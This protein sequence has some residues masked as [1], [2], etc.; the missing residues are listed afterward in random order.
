VNVFILNSGRCGSTTFIRACAHIKNFSAGHETRV[1]RIGPARLAYP[2]NHIEADNRLSWRLGSLDAVYGDRAWYVHL[3]RVRED[4]AGS[5]AKRAGFG[6][7]QAWREGVLLGGESGQ[8]DLD[9]AFDYLDA[10][11]ANI[12]HYLRDK[13]HVMTF[14]L[15]RGRE[16][17]R[18]FWDWI[19]ARGD[20]DAALAE[21]DVRHNAS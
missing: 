3:G 7:M 13:S 18:V 17:F 21:W 9:T 14:R 8:S 1:H 12:E 10:V 16:D 15:E 4:V 6:I 20:L 5:F 2:D 11:T 19:G